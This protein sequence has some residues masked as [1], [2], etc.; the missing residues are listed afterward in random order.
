VLYHF[1][2]KDRIL[3]AL[4]EP[5]LD[6]LE[7]ALDRA[8]RL[9][10]PACRWAVVEGLL[11]AFLIHRQALLMLRHDGSIITQRG[12]V[13]HRFLNVGSRAHRMIAGADAG[14]AERVHA[15][16]AVACLGDPVLYFADAPVD[17]LRLMILAGAR[18]MLGGTVTPPAE[19]TAAARQ[20]GTRADRRARRAGR[21]RSLD[22]ERLAAA[23][24]MYESGTRS[25]AEIAASLGVSR[26]TLYR[27]LASAAP[28]SKMHH[29]ET[30]F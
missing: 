9:D 24:R 5:L 20:T 17:E 10:Q 11:D 16:Q 29:S 13:Y 6:D 22:G 27:H 3:S 30:G 8:A 14:L 21:P 28:V 25:V 7:Q 19:R 26:A 4:T 18:R 12:D 2:A 23:R 15:A 1:P